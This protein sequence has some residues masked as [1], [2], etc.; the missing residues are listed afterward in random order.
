LIYFYFN[1]GNFFF[2]GT[3]YLITEMRLIN[4]VLLLYLWFLLVITGY[5]KGNFKTNNETLQ[6]DELHTKVQL[7]KLRT[8]FQLKELNIKFQLEKLDSKLPTS[9]SAIPTK[10][11]KLPVWWDKTWT[12]KEFDRIFQLWLQSPVGECA[13]LLCCRPKCDDRCPWPNQRFLKSLGAIADWFLAPNNITD[14]PKII[15]AQ[16][17]RQYDDLLRLAQEKNWTR[18][19]SRIL[20]IAFTDRPWVS[21]SQPAIQALIDSQ[22]F[23]YIYHE[24]MDIIM[25]TIHYKFIGFSERYLERTG[26]I[27]PAVNL[28]TK[29]P[30]V[31][32]S[33][34][35]LFRPKSAQIP[36]DEAKK[37]ANNA[38]FIDVFGNLPND[39]VYP[40]LAKYQFSMIPISNQ[41]LSPKIAE[42]L[43]F[44]TIPVVLEKPSARELQKM[45]MP[46]VIIQ[47]WSELTETN[48]N[49]WWKHL[50]PLLG[51][52]RW[53]LTIDAWSR[54]L[55]FPP[56]KLSS[57]RNETWVGIPGQW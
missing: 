17:R 49:L 57:V 10:T 47:D 18:D 29:F 50:S 38:S 2:R 32:A 1:C 23:S 42:S 43:L 14:D 24:S 31:F 37:Y 7:E 30:R 41:P 45:G 6:L 28:S 9:I 21:Q 48:M 16:N 40:T 4:A 33:W 46:I 11:E 51:E 13:F 26:H 44:Q 19:R 52:R 27:Y 20:V 39:K 36:R 15:M 3:S 8:K 53:L 35:A 22:Y 12:S 55:G 25:P 54:Q 5:V 34:G 56:E